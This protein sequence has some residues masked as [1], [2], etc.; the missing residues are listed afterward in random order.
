MKAL[1]AMLVC[2]FLLACGQAGPDVAGGSAV[3]GETVS[4][5]LVDSDGNPLNRVWLRVCSADSSWKTEIVTD[6]A[7][8]FR[9]TV[10]VGILDLILTLDDPATGEHLV[11]RIHL[12]PSLDTTLVAPRWGA[13]AGRIEMPRGWIALR[14]EQ[15]GL[16]L[17]DSIVSG[18]YRL[19]HVPP[20]SWELFLLADSA[21]I[22]RTLSLGVVVMPSGGQDVRRDLSLDTRSYL[23]NSY[24]SVTTV[25]AIGYCG[26]EGDTSCLE[27][28]TGSSAWSGTSLRISLFGQADLPDTAWLRP[29]PDTSTALLVN[30]ND[31]ISFMARGTGTFRLRLIGSDSAIGI[32]VVL[33]PQWQRQSFCVRELL[34]TAPSL[35][36]KRVGIFTSGQMFLVLDDLSF[37]AP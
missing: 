31:S 13:L 34:G 11:F 23:R 14:M 32:E 15:P 19:A 17:S 2:V 21:G 35:A 5:R 3:E 18:A 22:R 26:K 12:R 4:A 16:G 37:A 6:S 25:A 29:I 36:V 20:G 33:S 9:V 24:D 30:A 28:A 8:N 27:S 1:W 7:G 10:P